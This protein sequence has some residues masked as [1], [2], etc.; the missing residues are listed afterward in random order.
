MTDIVSATPSTTTTTTTTTSNGDHNTNNN[1]SINNSLS[2]D[3]VAQLGDI[4]DTLHLKTVEDKDCSIRYSVY[5]GES[6]IKEIMDLIECELSEPYSIFTYRF[7]L[8]MWPQLCF[9]A[10]DVTDEN[11][12]RLVGIVISKSA[13]HGKLL[14]G[15][16]GMIVVDKTYRRLGIGSK[17][18]RYTVE[19][20]TQ[21]L[22]DEIVLETLMT[23][24]QAIALYE[25]L[26][27]IRLKRLFGYYTMGEDAIRL[28]LPLNQKFIDT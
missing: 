6:Q 18:V 10:H 9:L 16:I 28:L 4:L 22:C 2:A 11:N 23:N 19:K 17:L 7:F 13:K 3:V 15:Y 12:K 20:M 25:G 21:M 1:N 14:R 26:G 8:G 5:K 27:F 24:H